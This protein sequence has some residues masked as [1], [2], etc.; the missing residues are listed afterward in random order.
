MLNITCQKGFDKKSAEYFAAGRKKITDVS[1]NDDFTLTIL[2]DNG[3]KRLLDA[4]VALAGGNTADILTSKEAF[5]RVYL[6]DSRCISLDLDPSVDSSEVWENK[7]DL[8]PD[9]CYIDS[10]PISSK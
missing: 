5:K 8:C 4:R 9:S 10:V 2:F 3:E 6:D 7:I 1:A